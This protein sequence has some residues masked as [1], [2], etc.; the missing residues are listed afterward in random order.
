MGRPILGEEA[1]LAPCDA[2]ALSRFHQGL[3]ATERLVVSVA[4]A[5]G[6]DEALALT[7]RWF[8]DAR[9]SG[10]LPEP[11]PATFR[12]GAMAETRKLEQA[13]SVMLLPG[14]GAR[15]DDYFAQRLFTEIL[16]GGMASRLFQE[17]REARG[18][19]YAI[20]AYAES[21]ED[22]GLVGVYAGTAAKDAAPTAALSLQIV[23]D[24]AAGPTEAELSRAK[25]QARS[26]LYMARESP[27]ARAEHAASQLIL[28]DRLFPVAELA[29]AL[30]A[31][32]ASD[33]AR[34][35]QRALEGRKAM[36]V[37]GPKSAAAAADIVRRAN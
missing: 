5:V 18:L 28:F 4:G 12:G 21:Y 29:G 15:H 9:S 1:S 13:H 34:I 16:G 6:E 26:S 37:L 25:A 33:V 31:V 7:E 23:A 36:A 27:M 11:A 17:A 8:G 24:L 22:V 35:G 30:D 32:S 19:A 3:Y 2:A 14:V 10:S 20:D